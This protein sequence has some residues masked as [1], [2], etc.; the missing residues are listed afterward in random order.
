MGILRY[1]GLQGGGKARARG[2][3]FHPASGFGAWAVAPLLMAADVDAP[4]PAVELG[5]R[6]STPALTAGLVLGPAAGTIKQF[7]LVGGLFT[8][9]T[10]LCLFLNMELCRH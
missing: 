9:L 1:R 10:A 2:C 7:W 5:L 6:Y 4:H 8:L 3:V